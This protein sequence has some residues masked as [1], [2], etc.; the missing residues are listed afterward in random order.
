MIFNSL[1]F[2]VFLII[3]YVLYWS[4]Q[5]RQQ[6]IL[7]LIASYVFYGWWDWRFLG[8]LAL[9]SAGDW[10]VGRKISELQS[11]A[12]R[13]LVLGV[14][15]AINLGVLGFFKYFNFFAASFADMLRSFGVEPS[16]TTLNVILP[17]GISFY[18][19]QSL[20]Y[21]IDVYRGKCKPQKDLLEFLAFVS[22]F[23]Q[24]VAG[25]IERAANLLV[26]F[27][28]DRKFDWAAARDG[29]CQM[30]WGFF[31]KIVVADGI[32]DYINEAYGASG[33]AGGG[34]LLLA[35]VLFFFQIY[36][37]FSGYTNIALGCARLLGFSLMRNFAYPMFSRT[38]AEFWQRWH[39][40][41]STWFRDYIFVP[42]GANRGPAWRVTFNIVVTF[43]VSGLWHGANWTF[44]IWGFL[45]GLLLV[46]S[47]LRRHTQGKDRRFGLVPQLREFVPISITFATIAILL[48]FFRSRDLAQVGQI[49]VSIVMEFDWR[50]LLFDAPMAKLLCVSMLAIEWIRRREQHPFVITNL[51]RPLRWLAYNMAAAVILFFGTF[52]Y[53]PFIYFQF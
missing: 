41:L 10:W 25:P 29:V 34:R 48:V 19:F 46:P 15:L 7:L 27:A 4:L 47:V 32:A 23:P 45:N 36:A 11:P 51:P 2:F 38:I 31:Q 37:D 53:A 8:L 5:R 21:T 16:F 44:V 3:V 35:T 6:N 28:K 24:L 26:Q 12:K 30:L 52:S 14:S 18:T 43:T 9:S 42:L 49:L 33:T 1:T 17:V 50:A 39:I 20:G 13:K 40:S 22:F